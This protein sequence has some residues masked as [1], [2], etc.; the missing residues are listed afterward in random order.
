MRAQAALAMAVRP[1]A[2]S[3]GSLA[4]IYGLAG[5]NEGNAGLRGA[6]GSSVDGQAWRELGPPELAGAALL[7][8]WL[9]ACVC[10]CVFTGPKC[11]VNGARSDADDNHVACGPVP[12][13]VAA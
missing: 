9:R 2:G 13:V 10:V 3:A 11:T 4:V 12:F 5:V 6:T 1:L 8:R 7:G